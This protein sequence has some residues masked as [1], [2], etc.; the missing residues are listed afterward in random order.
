MVR[1]GPSDNGRYVWPLDRASH[2]DRVTLKSS[3]GML[4]R[5]YIALS[6]QQRFCFCPPSQRRSGA[7]PGSPER[8]PICTA[9]GNMPSSAHM[10]VSCPSVP[11]DPF[12][13]STTAQRRSTATVCVI[14]LTLPVPGALRAVAVDVGLCQ[15]RKSCIPSRTLPRKRAR[16]KVSSKVKGNCRPQAME[17]GIADHLWTI[18]ELVSLLDSN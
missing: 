4:Q 10:G 15:Y 14:L 1:Y 8:S 12:S 13:C 9:R 16:P 5:I 17:T 2:V 7:G 11:F 6:R 3:C 18:Q